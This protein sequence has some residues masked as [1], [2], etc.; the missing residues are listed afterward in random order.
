MTD[1]PGPV[2]VNGWALFAHPLIL[3]QVQTIAI[4]VEKLK[5]KN[6]TGYRAKNPTKRLAAI[7]KLMF[8]VIPQDPTR[9]EYRQGI[10]LGLEHKHWFR[11]K[12]FQQYRLFFRYHEPRKVIVYALV[13]DETTKRAYDSSGK[14][15][16]G[17]HPPDNW[18]QLLA[19]AASQLL[20]KHRERSVDSSSTSQ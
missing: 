4:Q 14:M 13:N 2:I 10:T 5:K 11:A 16:E 9:T 3:E 6:P 7:N 15:L 19:E 20:H 8:D 1:A 17:G 12:F 18:D